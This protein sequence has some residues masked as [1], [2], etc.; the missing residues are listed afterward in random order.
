DRG[1][2]HLPDLEETITGLLAPMTVRAV[3]GQL[4]ARVHDETLKRHNGFAL[5]AFL[6]TNQWILLYGI[7]GVGF[8]PISSH[9]GFDPLMEFVAR[10]GRGVHVPVSELAQRAAL[11]AARLVVQPSNRPLRGRR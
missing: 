6:Q 10:A 7:R 2:H 4:A 1:A 11:A 5:V 3:L 8:T 9:S